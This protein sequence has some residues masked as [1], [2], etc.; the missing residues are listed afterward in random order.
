MS[1]FDVAQSFQTPG[2]TEIGLEILAKQCTKLCLDGISKILRNPNVA[3]ICSKSL[4][5][6]F[7][8]YY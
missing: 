7:L 8:K 4:P 5:K 3:T 6:K 2:M 1:N